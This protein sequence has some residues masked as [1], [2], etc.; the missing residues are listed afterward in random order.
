MSVQV[1]DHSIIL[2]YLICYGNFNQELANAYMF[3]LLHA[4]LE[5]TTKK[6]YLHMATHQV[7]GKNVYDDILLTASTREDNNQEA[8][9][10]YNF[11]SYLKDFINYPTL[12]IPIK[13]Y[14]EACSYIKYIYD[15]EIFDSKRVVD[16]EVKEEDGEEEDYDEEEIYYS[17]YPLHKFKNIS[18]AEKTWNCLLCEI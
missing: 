16:D 18:Y 3:D 12:I 5:E 4:M 15:H 6:C 10:N 17:T 14:E 9:K 1:S 2:H 11:L 13:N 7:E 8:K